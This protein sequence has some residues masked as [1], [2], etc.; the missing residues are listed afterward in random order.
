MNFKQKY[1][2]ACREFE[3]A[4]LYKKESTQIKHFE[5]ARKLTEECLSE[6]IDDAHGWYLLG[7]IWYWYPV[8]YHERHEKCEN[9]LKGAIKLNP[10]YNWANMYL[11][12]L[13]FDQR[14]FDLALERFEAVEPDYFDFLE[15]QHWR[16]LKLE[17]LKLCCRFYLDF[18]KVETSGVINLSKLYVEMANDYPPLP[19]EIVRCL[20]E[21]SQDVAKKEKIDKATNIIEKMTKKIGDFEIL[22]EDFEEIRKNLRT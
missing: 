4:L 7:S 8:N 15:G 9:A 11:G 5:I 1:T 13:Y 12:H 21:L 19:I 14:K 6:K 22:K 3:N 18:T 17:E 10:K 2:K 16:I 20:K